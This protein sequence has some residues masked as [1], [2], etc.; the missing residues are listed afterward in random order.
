M[1]IRLCQ[2]NSPLQKER[3]AVR[4]HELTSASLGIV[5]SLTTL[6]LPVRVGAGP[7][8]PAVIPL[9]Q[10]VLSVRLTR[11]GCKVSDSGLKAMSRAV[12]L[13]CSL[14]EFKKCRRLLGSGTGS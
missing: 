14:I 9:F 6:T 13:Q 4:T 5:A 7:V 8:I 10:P 11:T 3:P 1:L 2:E 12:A